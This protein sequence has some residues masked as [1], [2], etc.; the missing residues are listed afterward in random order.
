[1]EINL[2]IF[3]N[4]KENS[5]L[6]PISKRRKKKTIKIQFMIESLSLLLNLFDLFVY[7]ER[8]IKQN[9]IMYYCGRLNCS[10]KLSF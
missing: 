1:M 4:K 3:I 9:N 8:D 7:V 10:L 2:I 6:M 5:W